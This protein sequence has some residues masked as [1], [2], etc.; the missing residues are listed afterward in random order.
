MTFDTK[1]AKK[2]LIKWLGKNNVE[3]K[4]GWDKRG[5][6]WVGGAPRAVMNHDLVG[7]DQGAIDWTNA[8][9]ELKPY[10]NAVVTHDKVIINSVLAVFHSGLGGPWPKAGVPANV[11]SWYIWGTEH[12]VWGKKLDEYSPEMLGLSARLTCAVKEIAGTSWPEGRG[13]WSRLIRHASWTDGGPELGMRSWLP[14][15]S[16]KVDTLRPL[17]AWRQDAKNCWKGGA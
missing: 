3:F 10:C 2:V 12:A 17:L 9:G 14:T 7:V 1:N 5:D 4:S 11:G 15:R 13:T 6:Q 16:R 8:A